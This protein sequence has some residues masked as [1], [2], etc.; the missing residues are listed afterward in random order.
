MTVN[1]IVEMYQEEIS[2]WNFFSDSQQA[3]MRDGHIVVCLR[4]YRWYI[5]KEVITDEKTA[6][7]ALFEIDWIAE[8]DS[9]N[10]GDE[11]IS[12]INASKYW[13]EY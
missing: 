11:Q 1:E 13:K 6:L 2:D 9:I 4:N 12:F 7:K 10:D 8:Y 5:T 3:F